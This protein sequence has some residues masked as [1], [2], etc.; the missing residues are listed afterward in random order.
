MAKKK[1]EKGTQENP[2]SREEAI[3]AGIDVEKVEAEAEVLEAA[4]EQNPVKPSMREI[5]VK[6]RDHRGEVTERTFSKD[7]HGEDFAKL[8]NEFKATNAKQCEGL[9]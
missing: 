1:A 3:A 8:A 6:F 4:P 9:N 5:V 2:M 7:V